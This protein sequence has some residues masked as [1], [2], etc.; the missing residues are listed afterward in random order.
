MTLKQTVVRALPLFRPHLPTLGLILSA[1]LLAALAE[2]AQVYLVKPLLDQV[3]LKSSEQETD[4][5]DRRVADSLAARA[6]ELARA[7]AALRAEGAPPPPPLPLRLRAFGGRTVPARLRDDPLC[8]L[9]ER[10][11]VVLLAT[12]RALS[13][14]EEPDPL[15]AWA[16]PGRDPEARAPLAVLREAAAF[17]L[18]AERLV[19][20]VPARA[21]PASRAL[22]ARW[23][24]RARERA[25][26]ASFEAARQVL[27][28]LL[29]VA[30]GCALVL[31]AARYAQTVLARGL[32]VRI[33]RDLRV[34]LVRHVLSL[35]V[36]QLSE[37]RRGDLLSRLSSDLQQTVG[38]VVAPLSLTLLQQPFRVLVYLL[39]ALFL[40]PALCLGLLALGAVVLVPLRRL[41]RQIRAGAEERQVGFAEVLDALY[42]MFAGIRLV[43]VFQ[44][45]SYELE[46][47]RA[48]TEK[49]YRAALR[50]SRAR[51]W[52]R[53]LVRTTNEVSVP[54][55]VCGGSLLV[56]H[57]AL[58]LGSGTLVA[59]S[60]LILLMYRPVKALA[61]AYNHLQNGAPSFERLQQVFARKP[62]VSD[63]RGAVPFAGLREG[64]EVRSLSHSYDG[65]TEVLQDISFRAPA[66]TTTA[67]VGHTGAGKSTLL[68]LLARFM[69]PTRGDILVDGVSLRQLDRQSYLARVAVVSQ[70]C[71]VFNDSIRENIRYGRLE[72]SDEEVEEAA[73]A[74]RIHEEI[75]AREGGY[76]ALAGERG[77]KLS[78]G[79]VQRLTLAR[80]FV[81][82][83]EILLLDEAT[84]ALDART[85]RLIQE[86]IADLERECTTFVIAHR[87]STVRHADQI[88]VLD[89]GRLVE[90][91]THE[92]LL[93][94]GGRYADLVAEFAEAPAAQP[95]EP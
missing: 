32:T 17:Q 6:P 12:E 11:R 66:G 60:A 15:L 91:G 30:M 46:R 31:A 54:L 19:G 35:D 75:V 87:L 29:L 27:S 16:T 10:S 68:D 4:A 90:Q 67:I 63:A 21:A 92:E 65:S 61:Q 79:Q 56:V 64:I 69:D 34:D 94:R 33:A 38:S 44:R 22:A 28:A 95:V 1:T 84:S 23:S 41:G 14:Q 3:L 86:A 37:Q 51:A 26:E 72:A 7:E 8:A 52:S 9:L 5:A 78:G 70:E 43:K 80:A 83:P 20:E 57:G 62:R 59:F 25:R 45:E 40:S 39:L 42:Q 2:G 85:E 36:G 24:L 89:G 55:V 13:R 81:R 47:V 50:V 18:A 48:L 73:R 88:L 82:R 58:G 71:F 77:G 53:T 93:A 76:D 49:S 74:A